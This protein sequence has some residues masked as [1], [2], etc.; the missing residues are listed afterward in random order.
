MWARDAERCLNVNEGGNV[1]MYYMEMI[2][3]DE[4]EC[5]HNVGEDAE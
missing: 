4:N 5:E 3:N 1:R 2:M